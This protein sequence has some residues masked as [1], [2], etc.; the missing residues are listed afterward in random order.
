LRVGGQKCAAGDR[1]EAKNGR[2]DAKLSDHRKVFRWKCAWQTNLRS[3]SKAH[4]MPILTGLKQKGIPAREEATAGKPGQ[5][6]P[7]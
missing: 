1:Q 5:F 7:I 2:G 6:W 3:G 4:R